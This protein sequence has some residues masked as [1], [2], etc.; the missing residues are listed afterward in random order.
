M[1]MKNTSV[2]CF[3]LSVWWWTA[4]CINKKQQKT[5][6][7]NNKQTNILGNFDTSAMG[8][9]N[10][11]SL[12]C[13]LFISTPDTCCLR[14]SVTLAASQSGSTTML[15]GRVLFND[16]LNTFYLRLYGVI[17]MVKYH[18]D[19]KGRNLLLPHRLLFTISSKGSFICII[20]QTG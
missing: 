14:R 4:C 12:P 8:M 9:V 10:A 15:K 2:K 6:T 5:T 17:H 18:S 3:F 1:W 11:S 7:N 16:A 19:Y 13:D 20:P